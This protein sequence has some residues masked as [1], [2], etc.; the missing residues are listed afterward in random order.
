MITKSDPFAVL[1]LV[2]AVG[3]FTVPFAL[4]RF[5]GTEVSFLQIQ[6]L[7]NASA[8]LILL[9]LFGHRLV[10]WRIWTRHPWLILVRSLT[11]AL[12]G[13][14]IIYGVARMPVAEAMALGLLEGVIAVIFGALFLRERLSFANGLIVAMTFSGG[15]V[16]AL[17]NG[18]GVDLEQVD[19]FPAAMVLLGAALMAVESIFLRMLALRSDPIPAMLAVTLAGTLTMGVPALAIWEPMPLSSWI[20]ILSMGPVVLIGQYFNM[21]GFRRVPVSIAAPLGYTSVVFAALLGFFAFGEMPSLA[22]V[23]GAVVIVGAGILLARTRVRSGVVS[24]SPAPAE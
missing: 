13:G 11:G 2:A 15:I 10:H 7:R 8:F 18:H 14:L 23:A 9:A 4:G 5:V 3:L 1:L 22:T 12:G 16:V 24:R 17:G 20:W 19:P 6:G 21:V